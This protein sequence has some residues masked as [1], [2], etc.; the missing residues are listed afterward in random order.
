ML[1]VG[2]VAVGVR[3]TSCDG[4]ACFDPIVKRPWPDTACPPACPPARAG[5][6]SATTSAWGATVFI[7]TSLPAALPYGAMVAH[8]TV[9]DSR[10][11]SEGKVRLR[12]GFHRR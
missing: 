12:P 10:L 3:A 2:Q 1:P 11:A 6:R 9:A 5:G 7:A 8:A 4:R